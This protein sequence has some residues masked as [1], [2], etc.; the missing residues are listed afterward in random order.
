MNISRG[1]LRVACATLAFCWTLPV[2]AGAQQT[3]SPPATASPPATP[4]PAPSGPASQALDAFARTWAGVTSYSAI[5]TV[6]EQKGAQIQ[7]VVFDYSFRK[8]SSVTVHVAAGPNAG[9]TLMWDGGTTVVARRGSGLAALFKRRLPLHDPLVT[10]IRGSSVDQLSFG[11]ILAHAQQQ[12]A[13]LSETPGDVIDGVATDAVTVSTA[14][15]DNAG[16]TREV[17]EL[18]TSTHV[19]MRVLGFDGETLVRRIEFSNVVLAR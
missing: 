13:R 10:T 19:P 5:V 9:V 6:F 16:L 18:S 12:S 15:A 7:N 1:S 11:A 4:L 3:P 2:L 17:V 14:P 8:P